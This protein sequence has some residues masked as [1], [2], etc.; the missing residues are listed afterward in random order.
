MPRSAIL[1]YFA[2]I[3]SVLLILG[4]LPSVFLLAVGLAKGSIE[5]GQVGYFGVK[6]AA[7]L[8]EIGLLGWLAW[9]LVRGARKCRQRLAENDRPGSV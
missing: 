8:I 2:A 4:T 3:F 7:Y 5:Q 9:R 6:L 1:G